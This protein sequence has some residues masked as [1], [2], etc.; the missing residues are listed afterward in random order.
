ML[1]F[2]GIGAQKSGT[3]WLYENLSRHPQVTFPAGKEIHFWDQSYERG[4]SWYRS[5][6]EPSDNTLKG[7]ITPAYALLAEERIREIYALNS[8]LRILYVIR[9]PIERAWSAALMALQRAEM[10][11]EEA[12]DQ[13]FIDHFRSFGSRSR[14]DYETCLR[15]WRSV[16]PENQ[17]LVERFEHISRTPI[18]V[19]KRCA[20]HIGVDSGFYAQIDEM[21]LRIPVFTGMKEGIRPSL[22][23]V[24]REIYD[25]KIVCLERYL[26]EDLRDW[27][28]NIQLADLGEQIE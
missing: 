27:N 20:E 24:L 19:L 3:T 12:S 4:V 8:R 18:S 16:Y 9:N 23:A 26:G 21:L 28:A 17:V 14:G 7:E 13:W 15:R 11:F 10:T 5:L 6:F 22:Y 25:P 2:L 1:D